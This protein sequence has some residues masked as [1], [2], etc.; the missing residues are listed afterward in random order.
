[1]RKARN[2]PR[3]SPRK[4]R[5]EVASSSPQ[6]LSCVQ[7]R[8]QALLFRRSRHSVVD[9]EKEPWDIATPLS[10]SFGDML[11]WHRLA[12]GLTQEELAEEAGLSVRGLS[13]LERGARRAP[14]RE[15]LQLLCEALPLSEAERV[16]LEAAAHQRRLRHSP[17]KTF[18]SR[19]S[20]LPV[21]WTP[22]VG[23]EREVAA[24]QHLLS[25][26]GVH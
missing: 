8:C 26:E 3:I 19:P 24:V 18:E 16:R 25:R 23:R 1:M 17:L 21:Q 13:D 6:V 12:A 9:T 11:R 22:L 2:D 20:N 4:Q 15:T 7:A 10:Q 14:R 5:C